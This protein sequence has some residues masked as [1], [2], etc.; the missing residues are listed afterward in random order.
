MFW[1]TFL[2]KYHFLNIPTSFCN[3]LDGPLML[4]QILHLGIYKNM[5]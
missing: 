3:G 5:S 1:L 4:K 2:K